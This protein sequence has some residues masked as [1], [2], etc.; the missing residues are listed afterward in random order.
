MSVQK[1]K[2]RFLESV[3]FTKIFRVV[4]IE[5]EVIEISYKIT[6]VT[7]NTLHIKPLQSY[8]YQLIND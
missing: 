8:S 3:S 7:L 6:T 4:R 2:K 5:E 1:T